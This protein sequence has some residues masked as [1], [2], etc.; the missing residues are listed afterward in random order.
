MLRECPFCKGM[1]FQEVYTVYEINGET[2]AAYK[3]LRCNLVN[4]EVIGEG[5]LEREVTEGQD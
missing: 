4:E 1:T 2:R 5:E 3:C